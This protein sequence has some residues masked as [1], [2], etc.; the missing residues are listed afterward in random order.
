MP[1]GLHRQLAQAAER[2]HV[3]LNRFVT[4]AL[5]TSVSPTPPADEPA[6]A[7]TPPART[8]RM[9]LAANLLVLV[10]AAAVAAV[11]LVL[12]LERGI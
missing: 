1:S 4:E 2:E 8:I 10:L 3:S 6:D 7:R 11:L 9:V 5:A 12:A